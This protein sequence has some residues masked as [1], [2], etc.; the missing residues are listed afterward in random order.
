MDMAAFEEKILDASR[1]LE[2]MAHHQRLRILCLLMEGERSVCSLV[3][4][5]GLT[6]PAISHHLKKL[7]DAN[8]VKTRRDAQTIYYSLQGGEVESVLRTLNGIYCT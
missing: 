4:A 5:T 8:L 6:Q 3:D 7:R 1:L 2:M